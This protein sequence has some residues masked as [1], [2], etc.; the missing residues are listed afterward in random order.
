AGGGPQYCAEIVEGGAA[1]GVASADSPFADVRRGVVMRLDPLHLAEAV[2]DKLQA[3]ARKHS[4]HRHMAELLARGA[5]Q[6]VLDF[7]DRGETDMAAFGCQRHPGSCAS[8]DKRRDAQARSGPE[9]AEWRTG[10]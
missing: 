5:P 9:H 4:F 10:D 8:G 1:K 6:Q 3:G 2:I 7:V